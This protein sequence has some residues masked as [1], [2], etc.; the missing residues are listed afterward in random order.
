MDPGNFRDT[1][2]IGSYLF[3]AS[4]WLFLYREIRAVRMDI[5]NL[6]IALAYEKGRQQ[7]EDH[8]TRITRLERTAVSSH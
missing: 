8:E 6:R 7:G 5:N 1:L 3:G 4:C 2:L